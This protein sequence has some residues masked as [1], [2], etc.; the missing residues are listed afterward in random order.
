MSLAA[1]LGLLALAFTPHGAKGDAPR[2]ITSLPCRGKLAGA[3]FIPQRAELAYCGAT[4]GR[5]YILTIRQGESFFADREI[6]V[7]FKLPPT[8]KL[9]GQLLD[10][11]PAE[12]GSAAWHRATKQGISAVH[13]S[14][15][16][17][18]KSLPKTEMF[19][20]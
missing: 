14:Y 19:M 9:A 20:D 6:Q 7:F 16:Q 1:H 10:A 8:E 2:G 17:P 11:Q 3:A 18:G 5:S 13:L 12:F 15:M 4:S